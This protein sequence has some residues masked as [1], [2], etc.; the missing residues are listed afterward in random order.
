MIFSRQFVSGSA[1]ALLMVWCFTL[2]GQNIVQNGG[3]S[4]PNGTSVPDWT[5]PGLIWNPGNP[6]MP[7]ADGGSFVGVSGYIAQILNTQPNQTYLLQ[8]SVSGSVPYIGQG[9]P[10]GIG[11]EWGSQ[12][13]GTIQLS[14]V[15]SWIAEQFTVTATSSQTTL[16]FTQV[17]GANPW[18][19]AVSV[20]P[21]PEPTTACFLAVGA[22][23][24]LIRRRTSAIS[25]SLSSCSR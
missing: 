3:F 13:L 24:L 6:P 15:S 5:Y 19:D 14:N 16:K 23:A 1:V 11:V 25:F 9:G 20:T 2:R 17:Y 12:N 8:F 7:G 10:W 18:L 21:V 22:V 4:S